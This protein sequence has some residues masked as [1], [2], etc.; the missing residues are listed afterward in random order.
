MLLARS[1]LLV[2]QESAGR[3]RPDL[4]GHVLADGIH[5]GDEGHRKMARLIGLE[6]GALMLHNTAATTGVGERSW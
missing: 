1:D 4:V 3:V 5:P 6:V 2:H